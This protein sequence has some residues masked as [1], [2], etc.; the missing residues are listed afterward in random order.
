MGANLNPATHPTSVADQGRVAS[1]SDLLS[2]EMFGLMLTWRYVK[3]E[4]R[5]GGNSSSGASYPTSQ[6]LAKEPAQSQLSEAGRSEESSFGQKVKDTMHLTSHRRP[7]QDHKQKREREPAL[8]TTTDSKSKE[9]AGLHNQIGQCLGLS[10]RLLSVVFD[11]LVFEY[12]GR[13]PL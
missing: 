9:E 8:G 1:A 12:P 11:D 10:Y 13:C 5:H 6:W 3:A 4:M 7:A 2:L